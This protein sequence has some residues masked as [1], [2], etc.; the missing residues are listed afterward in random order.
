MIEYQFTLQWR[1]GGNRARDMLVLVIQSKTD[2]G[3]IQDLQAATLT[4][5]V[6]GFKKLSNDDT[7]HTLHVDHIYEL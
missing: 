5:L 2:R 1:D 6:S 3:A 7:F 4:A